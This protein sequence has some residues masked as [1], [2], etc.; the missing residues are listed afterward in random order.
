MK[1]VFTQVKAVAGNY[2]ASGQATLYRKRVD[3][4]GQLEIGGGIVDVPISAHGPISKPE[5]S[6]AWGAIAGAA[7]GTA[8]LPG[9]GTVI[10]AKIGGAVTGPPKAPPAS[11]RSR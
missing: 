5:F 10:G 8:V 3:A 1:T 9:I 2:T 4:Q 7:I 6:I 11:P